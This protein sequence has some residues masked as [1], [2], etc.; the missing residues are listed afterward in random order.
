MPDSTNI[1]R[2]ELLELATADALGVLDQVDAARFERAFS[3]AVPSVQA[4]VRALQDRLCA[5]RALLADEQPPASLRLKTLARVA[6]AIEEHTAA[7]APIATIG[8]ARSVRK[9]GSE[10]VGSEVAGDLDT[11]SRESLVREIL[12]RSALER[13]PT[14]HV[15]RAAALFLFA[16][17]V[18]ALYFNAQQ[19]QISNRLMDLVDRKLVDDAMHQVARTTQGFGFERAREVAVLDADGR[20]SKL[21]HAYLDESTNRICV[22]GFGLSG[23]GAPVR[24]T[25]G[26]A[27]QPLTLV[28]SVTEDRG[29]AVIFDR[30][31]AGETLHLQVD[32]RTMT[33]V[34]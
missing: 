11:A 27:E 5:E 2:D 30:P 6:G 9:I 17:L 20:P 10:R 15:W 16:A 21:I 18:V 3:S 23:S 28:A 14:Q 19:R 31:A 13:R 32:A 7:V 26:S 34:A 1:T 4:E 8:P 29:F 22:V 25:A 33:I 24:V 12:E